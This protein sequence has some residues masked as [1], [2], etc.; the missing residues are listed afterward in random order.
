[1]EG[2]RRAVQTRYSRDRRPPAEGALA[3]VSGLCHPRLAEQGRRLRYL[4]HAGQSA[5]EDLPWT[6]ATIVVAPDLNQRIGF[7]PD[8]VKKLVDLDYDT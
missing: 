6:W 8:E 5:Q 7:T 3:Y 4:T 1:L 2:A